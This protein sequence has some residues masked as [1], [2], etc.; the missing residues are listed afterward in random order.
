[1]VKKK[2]VSVPLRYKGAQR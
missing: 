1:M 2:E